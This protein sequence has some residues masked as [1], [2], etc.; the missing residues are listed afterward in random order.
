LSLKKG[1]N[2]EKFGVWCAIGAGS[3][4]GTDISHE[5]SIFSTWYKIL[6]KTLLYPFLGD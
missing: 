3:I 2:D 6:S 1:F 5:K 4:T